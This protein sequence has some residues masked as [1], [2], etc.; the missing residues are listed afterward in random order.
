MAAHKK[1][2]S[3]ASAGGN[4][5]G[6]RHRKLRFARLRYHFHRIAERPPGMQAPGQRPDPL[7]AF[8]LELERRTGARR[9]VRS[10]TVQDDF[11]VS[12]NLL[13]P[14]VEFAGVEMRGAGDD[15]GQKHQR[16]GGCGAHGGD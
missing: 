11:A 2:C 4:R 16:L 14:A 7:A 1:R 13:L 10:S 6:R 8:L 3:G 12:R 15:E 5:G 9:L